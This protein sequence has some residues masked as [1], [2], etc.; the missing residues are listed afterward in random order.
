MLENQK[1]LKVAQVCWK[2]GGHHEGISRAV[3]E[4]SERLSQDCDVYVYAGSFSG[5][6]T[7]SL[8]FRQVEVP[9]ICG[10]FWVVFFG[11]NSGRMI[12]QGDFDIVHLHVPSFAL[13]DVVTCHIFPEVM[14][15]WVN[16]LGKAARE[17]ITFQNRIKLAIFRLLRPFYRYNF[18]NN[19]CR[20][21]VAV[22]KAVKRDLIKLYGLKDNDVS[23]IPLGVDTEIFHPRNR[24]QYRQIIRQQLNIPDEI[25]LFIFIGQNFVGKGLQYLVSALSLIKDEQVHL[26]V[27]GS[28]E[29]TDSYIEKIVRKNG[30]EKFMTFVGEQKDVVPFLAAAD[31]FVSPSPYESF[32]LTILEGMASGLPIIATKSAGFAAEIPDDNKAGY[33]VDDP[34]NSKELAGV[35]R[36]V[37]KNRSTIDVMGMAARRIA[38]K[39]TWDANYQQTLALYNMIM[40]LKI[41]RK[42]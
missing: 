10:W 12:P 35:M 30:L 3:T 36:Q 13:A 23:V 15:G 14:L 21:V 19:R 4:L 34:T 33:I 9:G 25:F 26:L 40:D 6:E 39:Y 1:R 27:V 42:N 11:I 2:Y 16:S 5:V 7:S 38:E 41:S 8:K 37:I 32:G 20:S 28:G 22:S 29:G 18:V 24:E 17:W 31:I